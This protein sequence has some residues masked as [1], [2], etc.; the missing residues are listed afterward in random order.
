MRDALQ[1]VENFLESR[2]IRKNAICKEELSEA[3]PACP[4]AV[5]FASQFALS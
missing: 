3:A 4:I 2:S 5:I 1:Q